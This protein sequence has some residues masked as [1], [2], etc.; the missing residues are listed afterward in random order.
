MPEKEV[1][2][3]LGLKMRPKE[4]L[5]CSFP[6]T[7]GRLQHVDVFALLSADS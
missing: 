1:G 7:K 2:V 5:T 4:G 3:R 6:S